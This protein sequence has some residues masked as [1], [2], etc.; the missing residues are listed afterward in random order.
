MFLKYLGMLTGLL[1]RFSLHSYTA[2]HP[3][4]YIGFR[5]GEGQT[6]G[7]GAWSPISL[8]YYHVLVQHIT[9]EKIIK[10]QAKRGIDK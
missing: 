4:T 3:V 10:N 5:K 1:V 6:G 7:G 2:I 8:L 9:Y